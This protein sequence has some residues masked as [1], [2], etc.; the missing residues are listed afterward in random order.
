MLR[1]TAVLAGSISSGRLPLI[2]SRSGSGSATPQIQYR[3]GPPQLP[4]GEV[5][6]QIGPEY[7]LAGDEEVIAIEPYTVPQRK[8]Q[9][10]SGQIRTKSA[11]LI[12]GA[13]TTGR[14]V[15]QR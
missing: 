10:R 14:V 6:F 3:S 11:I 7:P 13:R 1:N 12:P 4:T 15:Q 2:Q 5:A 9:L 8:F